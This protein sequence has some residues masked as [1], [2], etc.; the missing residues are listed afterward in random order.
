MDVVITIIRK[1]LVLFKWCI[2]R[3]KFNS[4]TILCLGKDLQELI[5]RH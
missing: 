3:E 2:I 4:L 5:L 1:I